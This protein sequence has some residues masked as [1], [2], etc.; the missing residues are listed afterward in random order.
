MSTPL[1]GGRTFAKQSDA[2]KAAF[3]LKAYEATAQA[4]RFALL[5]GKVTSLYAICAS[6]KIAPV[7][8]NRFISK[9]ELNALVIRGREE[10][11]ARLAAPKPEVAP[12]PTSVTPT[13]AAST[14][15]SVDDKGSDDD[16]D[17]LELTK[18]KKV[19]PFGFQIRK[20]RELI[21]NITINKHRANL[22]LSQTG[23]GKTFML[24]AM[25]AYLKRTGFFSDYR[26]MYP[27]LYVTKASIVEQTTKVLQDCFG[28]DDFDVIVINIE[29]LRAK[30]GRLYIHE[31]TVIMQGQ[32]HT[33]FK[34]RPRSLPRLVIWDESQ[35][36]KNIDS[37]QSRIAQAL[38]DISDLTH[39]AE[40]DR[41]VQIFASATPFMRLC[42]TKCFA[43]ATRHNE[44]I[45]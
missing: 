6:L 36:L 4:V 8:D 26:G 43:V 25:M 29:Q 22:L 33:V 12:T 28:L 13:P 2:A 35:I 42:E 44:E 45:I 1:H 11:K 41:V 23:S 21:R 31:D 14:P 16:I 10:L 9:E 17:V 39:G 5:S 15:E 38:N 40:A 27:M 7:G 18:N 32:E 20:T 30:L 24:G 37:T 3:A 19:Q 34:W